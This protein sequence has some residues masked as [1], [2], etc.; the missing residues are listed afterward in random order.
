MTL[1][2]GI[3]P[4]SFSTTRLLALTLVLLTGSQPGLQAQTETPTG[5]AATERE[6][7]RLLSS[8]AL[9]I[10]ESD[11]L[12]Q[13][14]LLEAYRENAFEPFWTDPA[15]VEELL[16]LIDGA[17]EM[18][19]EYSF[20]RA[21]FQSYVDEDGQWIDVEIYEMEDAASA[22]GLQSIKILSEILLASGILIKG[23]HTRARNILPSLRQK[24]I[25]ALARTALSEV[26]QYLGMVGMDQSGVRKPW[27]LTFTAYVYVRPIALRR[28]P[29]RAAHFEKKFFGG[30]AGRFYRR[31][32]QGQM[33][34]LPWNLPY[35]EEDVCFLMDD[36]NEIVKE[37]V[38]MV[39]ERIGPVA[40]FK[41]ATVVKRLPKTRSGKILRGTMKKIADG[42]EYRMPATIDD[43]VI[44][45]E[46]TDALAELGYPHK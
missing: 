20:K 42:E 2:S 7:E 38:Q 39:R 32:Y 8:P 4:L 21:I 24:D 25:F 26:N 9:H 28:I 36:A 41:V 6:I 10:G 46:I 43:P 1:G 37:L 40:S 33:D 13:E 30:D 23:N 29:E 44:L 3:L 5:N 31:F 17:A 14:Q 27:K 45:D 16:R 34:P 15:R 19:F 22:Y 18:Y 11:I 12:A 35:A